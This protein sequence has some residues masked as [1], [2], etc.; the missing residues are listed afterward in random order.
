M[1]QSQPV[2]Y[3]MEIAV[4]DQDIDFLGH[5]NNV[6]YVDW[7]QRVAVAHWEVLATPEEKEIYLWVVSRHE[8]DYK[9]PVMRE[10]VIKARTWVGVVSKGV[11]ERHTTLHRGTDGKLAAQV[12]TLWCPIDAKTG[13][14][15]EVAEEVYARFLNPSKEK[16]S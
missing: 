13:K 12:R 2:A 1:K 16:P 5:V 11:F 14:P 7:V 3:E 4:Q 10:D 8:I 6:V 9:R 15:V